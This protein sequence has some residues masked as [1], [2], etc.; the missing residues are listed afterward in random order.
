MKFHQS[1][2]FKCVFFITTTIFIIGLG[3]TLTA[4]HFN[5]IR[6]KENYI[7][8][9]LSVMDVGSNYMDAKFQSIYDTILD[10]YSEQ[11]L[12]NLMKQDQ[13]TYSEHNYMQK[14]LR[15]YCSADPECIYGV[16]I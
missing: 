10:I 5:K 13:F 3:S 1:I 2:Q 12:Y 9:N 15:A 16:R 6:L 8:K 7:E 4:Y 11:T 14:L